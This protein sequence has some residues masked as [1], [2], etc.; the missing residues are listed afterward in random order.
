MSPG[1]D[2]FNKLSGQPVLVFCYLYCEGKRTFLIFMWNFLCS[3][4]YP[5]PFVIPLDV[6]EKRLDPC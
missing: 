4:M 2:T 1:K 6:T 5:L 3:S